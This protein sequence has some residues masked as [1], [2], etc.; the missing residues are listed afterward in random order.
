MPRVSPSRRMGICLASTPS[1]FSL[2]LFTLLSLVLL[3]PLACASNSQPQA[4]SS[5]REALADLD[6]FGALLMRAG[7]PPEF[8]PSGRELSPEQARQLRLQLHLYPLY[9]PKP[10]EHGPWTVADVLLLD[11]TLKSSAVSRAELGRRIQEFKPLLVLR[12]DGYLAEALTGRAGRCV[13]P[14][15]VKDNTYRAGIYELGVFYRPDENN[16]P[17]PVSVGGQPAAS[18]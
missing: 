4:Y 5:T 11:V 17:Q 13:G 1:R 6:E 10:V 2:G 15:E 14:V 16:E 3:S 8:L 18:R 12:P 9:P 7:L